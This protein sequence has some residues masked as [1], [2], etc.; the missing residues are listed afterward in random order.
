[1]NRFEGCQDI[2]LDKRNYKS[3]ED[4]KLALS[5]L[6]LTLVENDYEVLINREDEECYVVRYSLNLGEPD[7]ADDKMFFYATTDEME[8]IEEKRHPKESCDI[9]YDEFVGEPDGPD[10]KSKEAK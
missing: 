1:M 8:E 3:D 6:I 5:T 10:Y 7:F 2:S 9:T 4:F